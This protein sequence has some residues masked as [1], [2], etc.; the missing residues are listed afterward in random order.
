MEASERKH[1]MMGRKVGC[2]R[3]GAFSELRRKCLNA[4]IGIRSRTRA[5]RIVIKNTDD[6]ERNKLLP[7]VSLKLL[8]LK[9]RE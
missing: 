9:L 2:A 7:F 3:E 1:T 5:H 4:H 6:L 8:S